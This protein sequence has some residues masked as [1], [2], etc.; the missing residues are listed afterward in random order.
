MSFSNMFNGAF[1]EDNFISEDGIQYNIKIDI[2]T[3][4]KAKLI[5]YIR[6][7]LKIEK[8]TVPESVS[9]QFNGT[10]ISDNGKY[11]L[12]TSIPAYSEITNENPPSFDLVV[13]FKKW[14]TRFMYYKLSEEE[15]NKYKEENKLA[16]EVRNKIR[17][18]ECWTKEKADLYTKSYYLSWNLYNTLGNEQM[19]K[20][21]KEI[22]DLSNKIN[23]MSEEEFEDIINQYDK[24]LE[25]NPELLE[26]LSDLLGGY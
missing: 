10:P 22:T 4:F 6:Q 5:S 21:S 24:L 2:S 23:N 20:L 9:N 16:V 26:G 14:I 19:S 17:K 12:Y 15:F 11:V 25:E 8:I 13:S 7:G 3:I 1:L 18:D